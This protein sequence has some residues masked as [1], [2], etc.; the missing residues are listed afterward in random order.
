MIIK[1]SLNMTFNP[2]SWRRYQNSSACFAYALNT[3]EVGSG[4]LGGLKQGIPP[5]RSDE[6]IADQDFVRF[7]AI[8]DGLLPQ[9][10]RQF[11]PSKEHIIAVFTATLYSGF[12][13]YYYDCHHIRLD[14]DF[15]WSHK[16][17]NQDVPVEK[18]EIPA[19]TKV[20]E[21]LLDHYKKGNA[22]A[23][24]MGFYKIPEEGLQTFNRL[25]AG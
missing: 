15:S 17:G 14:G 2:Q 13:D 7:K 1:P 22:Q 19:D 20:S 12:G 21:H 5:W 24:F 18:I 3:R 10:E 16:P 9:E 8:Q 25:E 23:W 11:D 4:N 6:T